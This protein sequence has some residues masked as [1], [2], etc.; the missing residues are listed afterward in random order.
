M[1]RIQQVRK[2][3][4]GANPDTVVSVFKKSLIVCVVPDQTILLGQDVPL[5]AVSER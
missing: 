3:S 1:R 2:P 4:A 5:L